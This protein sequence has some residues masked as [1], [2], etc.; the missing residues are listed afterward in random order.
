MLIILMTNQFRK[1]LRALIYNVFCRRPLMATISNFNWQRYQLDQS[2]IINLANV[3][4]DEMYQNRC[5]RLNLFCVW[6]FVKKIVN[7][8]QLNSLRP[9]IY[10]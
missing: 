1:V 2:I 7:A 10:S 5:V 9:N 3:S 4:S 8:N 6:E